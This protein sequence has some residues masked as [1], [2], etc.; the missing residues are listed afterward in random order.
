MA[1]PA[2]PAAASD[3][4]EPASIEEVV[5][6]QP[7]R[8]PDPRDRRGTLVTVA[9]VL[10]LLVSI[11]GVGWHAGWFDSSGVI[12]STNDCTGDHA[13]R[14]AGD[15]FGDAA[16]PG[17][18]ALFAN[19][20]GCEV[21]FTS[22]AGTT[23]ETELWAKQV[24]FA[25]SDVALTAAQEAEVP[26][27]FYTIPVAIGAVAVVYDLPGSVGSVRL[28]GS[29][30]AGIFDGAV[31]TWNAAAIAALNPGRTLP[32][33]PITVVHPANASGVTFAFT[34][35]L[36]RANASWA[37]AVGASVSVVWP[38]GEAEPSDAAIASV[39]DSTPGAIGF[40]PLDTAGGLSV[41]AL[42]NPVGTF[43]LPGATN[44]SAAALAALPKL[45]AGL[46]DWQNVT[47]VDESGASTYPAAAFSYVFVFQDLGRAYGGSIP[48]ATADW[49]ASFLL[50][51]V[52]APAQDQAGT[53][54][55]APIPGTLGAS[56]VNIAYNAD[57]DSIEKIDYDGISL[58]GD[59]D[60]DG[61]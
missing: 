2:P 59:A 15:A 13:I 23:G 25:T 22:E 58:L 40:L 56:P 51:S 54:G 38:T 37:G 49:I 12:G 41:A 52:R 31:S 18:E 43:V 19:S 1:D 44:V 29:V 39:V 48:K 34:S 50:W 24:D 14:G 42:E 17:W 20:T 28:N 21:T 35:Y 7:L 36:A 46:A 3:G 10:V 9:A 26:N 4:T 61:L 30:L 32:S 5:N 53:L 27:K 45:P 16:L 11:L 60:N 33:T 6:R 47:L 57:V 55:F 8:R